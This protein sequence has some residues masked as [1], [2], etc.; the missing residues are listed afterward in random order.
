MF[1]EGVKG[2]K[3]GAGEWNEQKQ[4]RLLGRLG[5]AATFRAGEENE[6]GRKKGGWL[7]HLPLLGRGRSNVKA[8]PAPSRAGQGRL[9]Q[10]AAPVIRRQGQEESRRQGQ[11]EG[12]RLEKGRGQEADRGD[13][14]ESGEDS[15]KESG[16]TR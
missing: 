6:G 5:R 7:R 15:G 10:Y 13:K 9:G 12:R 8:A 2:W 14:Q 4:G 1:R 11:E 3:E 16:Y